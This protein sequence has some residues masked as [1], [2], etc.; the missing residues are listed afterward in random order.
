MAFLCINANSI[1]DRNAAEGTINDENLRVQDIHASDFDS[2]ESN[3]QLN[4]ENEQHQFSFETNDDPMVKTI[5]PNKSEDMMTGGD[6]GTHPNEPTKDLDGDDDHIENSEVP[7]THD[8]T[9]EELMTKT[10]I[11]TDSDIIPSEPVSR[12]VNGNDNLFV[13]EAVEDEDEKE[14]HHTQSTDVFEEERAPKIDNDDKINVSQVNEN[15]KPPKNMSDDS[16]EAEIGDSFAEEMHNDGEGEKLDQDSTAPGNANLDTEKESKPVEGEDKEVVPDQI[17]NSD[18]L[19]QNEANEKDK[20]GSPFDAADP[21]VSE[22]VDMEQE[23]KED[24]A[25]AEKEIETSELE[26][27][28]TQDEVANNHDGVDGEPDRIN[29]SSDFPGDDKHASESKDLEPTK[30]EN[31]NTVAENDTVDNVDTVAENVVDQ[32]R[33]DPDS[34]KSES[35][36]QVIEEFKKQEVVEDMVVAKEFIKSFDGEESIQIM[37]SSQSAEDEKVVAN[38]SDMEE[39]AVPKSEEEIEKNV[40]KRLVEP[41]V[42]KETATVSAE[43]Q[44]TE[45][46]DSG[47][48]QTENVRPVVVQTMEDPYEED[49]QQEEEVPEDHTSALDVKESDVSSVE[50]P[51]DNEPKDESVENLASKEEMTSSDPIEHQQ[52]KN[53]NTESKVVQDN[54]YAEGSICPKCKSSWCESICQP[55]GFIDTISSKLFG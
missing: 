24:M 29:L 12:E 48:S 27:R 17:A 8:A 5:E 46:E 25:P 31:L 42:V 13:D 26:D 34:V 49:I 15:E 36:E 39:L 1:S 19:V 20:P 22:K 50:A 38:T 9:N 45:E 54:T 35:H 37:A 4:A 32:T 11:E 52:S 18:D 3:Q 28:V 44:E 43:S 47:L 14:N 2:V 6:V 21:L 33:I 7:L 53:N 30:D 10:N 23:V 51:S 40:D 41:D 16:K 55:G